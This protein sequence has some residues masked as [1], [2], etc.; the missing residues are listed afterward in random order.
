VPKIGSAWQ[1]RALV[2]SEGL[3]PSDSP[4]RSLARSLAAAGQLGFETA[5]RLESDHEDRSDTLQSTCGFTPIGHQRLKSLL[6][7]AT[8]MTKRTAGG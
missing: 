6:V 4:T 3:R 5:S 7:A 1:M 2:L 8:A